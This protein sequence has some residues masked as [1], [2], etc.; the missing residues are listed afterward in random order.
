MGIEHFVLT[1][2]AALRDGPREAARLPRTSSTWPGGNGW[3]PAPMNQAQCSARPGRNQNSREI[4]GLE[5]SPRSITAALRGGASRRAALPEGAGGLARTRG[6]EIFAGRKD[7]GI[8]QFNARRATSPPSL[9]GKLRSIVPSGRKDYR[10]GEPNVETL[11][12]GSPVPS[13]RDQY[14]MRPANAE[15]LG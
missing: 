11:S 12:L 8:L 15:A 6:V 13:G 14:P 3:R 4:L 10:M 2:S 1:A 5:R 7:L 9:G